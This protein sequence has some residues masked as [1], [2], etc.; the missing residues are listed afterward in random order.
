MELPLVIRAELIHLVF[1]YDEKI[2]DA[3]MD[4]K[5]LLASQKIDLFFVQVESAGSVPKSKTQTGLPSS[6][7]E[8]A[9][10]TL[11]FT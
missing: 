6:L 10:Q 7:K 1:I 11:Y 3:K 4:V 5:I 2:A 9:P 8:C